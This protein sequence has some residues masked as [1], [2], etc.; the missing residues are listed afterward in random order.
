VVQIEEKKIQNIS[1]EEGLLTT[2][3]ITIITFNLSA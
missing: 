2:G 3:F 1:R